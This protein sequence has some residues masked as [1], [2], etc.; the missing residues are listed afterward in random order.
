MQSRGPQ[1]VNNLETFKGQEPGMADESSREMFGGTR[2]SYLPA[3]KISGIGADGYVI[4]R[5]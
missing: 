4:N 1:S 2:L 3:G 5:A